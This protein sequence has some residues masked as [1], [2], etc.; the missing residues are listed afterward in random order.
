MR[1]VM[2]RI[3]CLLLLSLFML[4]SL[5]A[6]AQA[7]IVD[8]PPLVS[9]AVDEEAEEPDE[10]GDVED[11]IRE[12]EE[13]PEACG[14]EESEEAEGDTGAYP[15]ECALRS[16]SA[17]AVAKH[18][19]LKVTVSYSTNGP[20]KATIQIDNGSI[21]IGSFKRRLGRSGVLR[22][23][24]PLSKKQRVKRIAVRVQLATGRAGCPSRRLVLFPGR[25]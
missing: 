9:A 16:A 1:E 2:A 8:L 23:T 17:R 4:L 14:E 15:P 5:S 3:A 21:R 19:K 18:G 7:A 24:Q 12:C 25:G 10:S 11:E 6:T 22:F 20:V 13:A